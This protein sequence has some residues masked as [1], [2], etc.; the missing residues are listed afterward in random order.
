MAMRLI[1]L[2]GLQAIFSRRKHGDMSFAFAR[3][4]ESKCQILNNRVQFSLCGFSLYSV[5]K[6]IIIPHGFAPRLGHSDKILII[7]DE[8]SEKFDGIGIDQH[9]ELVCDSVIT[10]A[11]NFPIILPNRDCYPVVLYDSNKKMMAVVHSGRKGTL[12]NIVGKTLTAMQS[13]ECNKEDIR[14]YIFPGI[15]GECY[16]LKYLPP[17]FPEEFREIATKA[18]NGHILLDLKKI[19]VHQLLAGGIRHISFPEGEDECTCCTREP[20]DEPKYFS[21]FAYNNF[22]PGHSWGNN[23]LVAMLT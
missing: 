4:A 8:I 11:I 20:D 19:I 23:A 9:G 14:S 16:E 12:L 5:R 13:L 15:C 6:S 10:N 21:Y 1:K 3:C 7:L 18:R 17:D 22:K 2:D